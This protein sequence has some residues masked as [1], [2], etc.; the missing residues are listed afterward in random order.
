MSK[1]AKMGG[2]GPRDKKKKEKGVPR[3]PLHLL[4]NQNA[5]YRGMTSLFGGFE[6]FGRCTSFNMYGPK[7]HSAAE[8]QPKVPKVN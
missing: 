7:A 5:P 8:P 3:H 1:W 4:V 6:S 2:G